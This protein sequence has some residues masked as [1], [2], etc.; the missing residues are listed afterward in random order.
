[1]RNLQFLKKMLET[2][3]SQCFSFA[4]IRGKQ[5]EWEEVLTRESGVLGIYT[6]FQNFALCNSNVINK[7]AP[8]RKLTRKE[9]KSLSKHWVTPGI[10]TSIRLKENFCKRLFKTSSQCLSP[11]T[12]LVT[13]F[14]PPHHCAV[15]TKHFHLTQ[16]CI[17]PFSNIE[18]GNG[19]VDTHFVGIII[20]LCFLHFPTQF[21]GTIEPLHMRT[22][23]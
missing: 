10:Q 9:T 23:S 12:T 7:H 1:M 14:A 4:Y 21:V 8:L 16:V 19:G 3:S 20:I 15:L 13:H 18:T 2:E 6:V 22:P 17:L 5:G 11:T